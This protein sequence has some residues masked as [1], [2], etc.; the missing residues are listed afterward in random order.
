TRSGRLDMLD[1]GI[2][3]V[4]GVSETTSETHSTARRTLASSPS[5]QDV[6][7][8]EG[9]GDDGRRD[10]DHGDGRGGHEHRALIALPRADETLTLDGVAV[11]QELADRI[12]LADRSPP[13][14]RLCA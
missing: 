7:E 12:V 2:E 13:P 8:Q 5:G 1:E 4:G 11:L 3:L 14:D 6:P 9:Y 10:S